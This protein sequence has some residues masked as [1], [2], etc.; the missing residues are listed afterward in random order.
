VVSASWIEK[1]VLVSGVSGQD[2]PYPAEHPPGMTGAF[3]T[4]RCGKQSVLEG[5]TNGQASSNRAVRGA[6][7]NEVYDI[8]APSSVGT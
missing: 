8:A 3:N 5:G 4:P 6:D 1:P 7:P 2:G